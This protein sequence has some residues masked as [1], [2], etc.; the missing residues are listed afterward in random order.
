M[1]IYELEKRATPGPCR[2][3]H[4][5]DDGVS[6]SAIIIGQKCWQRFNT[7]HELDLDARLIAHCRN[8]CLRALWALKVEHEYECTGEPDC[9]GCRLIKELEEV[10]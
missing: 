8:N 5:Y 4:T 10:K 3:E 2:V 7:P 6:G 9:G 1:N